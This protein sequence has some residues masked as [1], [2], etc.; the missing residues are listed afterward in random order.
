MNSSRD[1][2]GRLG[3]RRLATLVS[4]WL[5]FPL[6]SVGFGADPAPQLT[7]LFPSGGQRGTTIDVLA[8]G[9]FSTWP[10]AIVESSDGLH[11]SAAKTKGRL[12]V[13]VDADARRGIHWLR[14]GNTGGVS[15]SRPF[16]VG[17]LREQNESEPN[18]SPDEAQNLSTSR[19]V[20]NGRL[21]ERSDVDVFGVPLI[22][23]ETLVAAIRAHEVFRSPMDGI[24]QVLS[25]RGFV[26]AQSNDE[27]GLD[28]RLAYR[29]ETSGV[30]YVR[31]FAFSA[32]PNQT[33][34]YAYGNDYIYRLTLTTGPFADYLLPLAAP[35]T[36]ANLTAAVR[37]WN[38]PAD[39][40]SIDLATHAQ[41][42]GASFRVSRP[43]WDNDLAVERVAARVVLEAELAE[44]GD[45]T[46]RLGTSISGSLVEKGERDRYRF[47]A[48]KGQA[49]TFAVVSF[50]LGLL[51]D[52]VL[53]LFDAKG[54][55]LQ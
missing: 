35:T 16:H 40:S 34:R 53:R 49:I 45:R 36:S 42:E 22:A 27:I 7:H 4:A 47:D 8:L 39:A 30:Y 48:K 32:T 10:P 12:R 46:L 19:L 26:V 21:K 23:G 50:R 15:A 6:C 43:E 54:K 51:C 37:G 14:L 18:S 17:K 2:K 5:A 55:R 44:P 52:P 1:L 31:L 33:I 41:P 11:W 13:R 25:P 38:L 28:P 9:S 24:L 20:M 29:A 3:F